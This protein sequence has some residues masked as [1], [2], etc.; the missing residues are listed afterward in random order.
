[1]ALRAARPRPRASAA[2]PGAPPASRR[3]EED[4][5]GE[6]QDYS[7]YFPLTVF[8]CCDGSARPKTHDTCFGILLPV[9]L[10]VEGMEEIREAE[11]LLSSLVAKKVFKIGVGG[12]LVRSAA[13]PP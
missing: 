12:I 9:G 10:W 3:R 6:F 13:P 11:I 4:S 5:A 8:L 7:N 1:M 2:P